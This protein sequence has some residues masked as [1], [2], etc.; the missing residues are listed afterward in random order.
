GSL[1]PA[2][3][4]GSLEHTVSSGKEIRPRRSESREQVRLALAGCL[5]GRP[6]RALKVLVRAEAPADL[7]RHPPEEALRSHL[8][9][10]RQD[11]GPLPL[12]V[13][14]DL[15]LGR[16]VLVGRPEPLEPLARGLLGPG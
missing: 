16:D 12:V 1:P 10:V 13:G 7:D 3:P 4:L 11:R 9:P 14:P 6:G 5:T 8:G 2:R 15:D